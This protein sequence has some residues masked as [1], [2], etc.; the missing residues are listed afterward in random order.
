MKLKKKLH[1]FSK[2]NYLIQ[3][4]I[5]TTKFS[6]R[7]TQSLILGSNIMGPKLLSSL[8]CIL[9]NTHQRFHEIFPCLNSWKTG[10]LFE[11]IHGF[12]KK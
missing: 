4:E 10:D 11:T 1:F 2:F 9:K 6:L 12:K 7:S 3:T 5:I 8:S